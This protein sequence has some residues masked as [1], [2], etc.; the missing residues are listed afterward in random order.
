M[1]KKL[2]F[3]FLSF[4]PLLAFSQINYSP[5]TRLNEAWEFVRFDLG[6][7]W[8]AVRPAAKG[9]P[10]TYPVWEK[11]DLP[12]CFNA[13]DAVDPDVNYYQGPGWYRKNLSID[14]PYPNGRTIL[15]FEGAGQKT[16]V[17]VYTQQVGSHLGGYD[18]WQVDI[19]D[20]VRDFLQSKDA[21][22]LNGKI[23]L[24]IRCDNSRNTEQIPS[25]LSDFTIYGGIYRY[26]NLVYLPSLAL[27]DIHTDAVVDS[28]GKKGQI[29]IIPS[30]FN[31]SAT[32]NAQVTCKLVS[33]SGKLITE[34]TQTIADF[35]K[36]GLIFTFELAKPE[37]WSPDSPHLYSCELTLS[38]PEGEMTCREVFGFRH[39]EF[40]EKGPFYLNGKRLLL[41]GTHRHE[42]H[43]GLGA[44]MTEDL[45]IKEMEMIKA[46]GVNFIRLGHYQ[47]SRIVLEQCDKLGILVWEEIPWCRGGLGGDD[48]RQ[49]AK[50]MLTN[51]IRQHRNHPAIILWGLGNE[52]DWPNDFPEFDKEKIR[53][54]MKELHDLAHSLDDSRKTCIR[55]C[56]FCKDIVDVYSPSIWAGWYR[57][58]YTDYKEITANEM[59]Q[60]DRFLHAEWGGDS[61]ARRYA[62]NSYEGLNKIERSRNADERAG[63]ASFYA[64]VARAS[65]DGDWSE[66]YIC[67]LFDWH[68]KEQETMPWLTGAAAWIFKDFSTPVRQEN[69]IPYMNQKGVVERDLTP[70]ESYYV[71]QSY[72]AD[73]PMLHVFGHTW[74][75]RWGQAHEKKLLK[76]YS[77][78]ETVE[79]FLNGL[80]LGMK[81]RNSQDFP[82]AGL[83]W[84]ST[85][86]AGKN[87]LKAIGKKGKET[88]SDEITFDYEIRNFGKPVAI[89]AAAIESTDDYAW[90]EAEIVDANG[91]VCLNSRQY[92]Y[93]ESIGDGFLV[94]NQG[95]STGSKKVQAQNGRARIK[96]IKNR[97]QNTVAI[98]SDDLETVF[99]PI[100]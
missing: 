31:Y 75:I 11:V 30:F 7:V 53:S 43:A 63:D 66:N 23:P 96:L 26:L 8:E 59:Q 13:E 60:T 6:S 84:E 88:L 61:H 65:K 70:K 93:F 68:L 40:R 5:K 74:P 21:A 41:R 15:H 77:N 24:I 48:Y 27:S 87:S 91:V 69:P 98:K 86:K 62:E 17:Y 58:L 89:K 16:D 29:T 52:N 19:T 34:K 94:V 64:G 97:G 85:L 67:D 10:E 90:I 38:S 100:L 2:F 56:D 81:K 32:K 73:K 28:A 54:F 82:A 35:Y 46:M 14:N 42:D 83:R 36:P 45:I 3:L 79:L 44:A 95:T 47:Q 51:L 71:F 99:I 25:D 80:S 12:H 9:A 18:E 50:N 4:F 72:W 57:G 33:P 20:A 37:L 39:F 78:C 49:M 92:L 1:K 55:R 76:V 22:R